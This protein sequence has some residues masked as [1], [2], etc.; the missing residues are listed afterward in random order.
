MSQP[1]LAQMGEQQVFMQ[2]G[3]HDCRLGEWEC[4]ESMDWNLTY[5]SGTIDVSVGEPITRG[6]MPGW[7]RILQIG[8]NQAFAVVFPGLRSLMTLGPDTY[9]E[10][11]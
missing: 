2:R 7:I 6:P 3:F 4:G 1:C 11:F 10:C 8:S 9:E 5:M